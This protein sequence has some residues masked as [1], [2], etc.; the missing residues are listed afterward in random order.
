MPFDTFAEL[1]SAFKSAQAKF[2]QGK[3]LAA[4]DDLLEVF[5]YR[6]LSGKL[7]EG[8]LD[9]DLKVMQSLADLAALFGEFQAADDLL[10]S[11]V[12][13]Y[14]K[15]DNS[16]AAD[17]THLRRIQLC[18]DR[19]DLNLARNLL[20]E[21]APRIGNIQNIQF[22]SAGLN[23]WEAGCLWRNA[24][25]EDRKL[26]F[27]ELYFAMGRLLCS[28]GQYGDALKALYRSILYAESE[29]APDLAKQ[30]ILPLQ[31]IVASAYLEK[32]DF[33]KA[34]LYLQE[35]QNQLDKPQYPEYLIRW[36]ELSA[37]L[38]LLQGNFGKAFKNF[39]QVQDI[40]YKFDLRRA[41]LR[42][43]LNLAQFLILINQTNDAEGYLINVQMD[44]ITNDDILLARRAELLLNIARSR[45]LSLEVDSTASV[46]EML[47]G[48]HDRHQNFWSKEALIDISR[49][50]PNYLTWFEDRALAFQCFLGNFKIKAAGNLLQQIQDVFQF[51]DS[52]LIKVKI[53][54]LKGTFYYY[55]SI[56][57][58][59]RDRLLQANNILTEVCPQLAA[60]DLKPELWQVQRI[61]AWCRTSLH[62]PA[63]EIEAL[64]TSTNQLLEQI[65]ATLAPEDQI[66][67]LLNKWT[68][69]E[70]Y[71]AAK[72]NQ[73]QRMERNL[74]KNPFWLRLWYW[75]Q[76]RQELNKLVEHIDKYKGVLAKRIIQ[77]EKTKV[78][79]LRP[80]SLW[81]RFLTHPKH[82][83]SISFLILPDRVLVVITG[84][85]LFDFYVIPTTR[86]A[87]RNFIQRWYKTIEGINGSRDININD[88]SDYT[89]QMKSVKQVGQEIT[90]NLADI[91]QL[92]KILKRLPK[93]VR[94]LTIVPDDILHGFPF[95]AIT[96][97]DKY[98]IEHYALSITYESK[99]RRIKKSS[100]SLKKQALVIGVSN[101][102]RQFRPLP[103]VRR[104]L[105]RVNNWLE[106]H[107]INYLLLENNSACKTAVIESISQ[108]TLLHIACHGTFKPNQPDQSGLV[109]ISHTGEQQILSLR[110]LSSMNLTQLR[111]AT[112]S[113]CWSADHFILPR[114]WIISL[115]ETLWRAGTQSILGCMWEVD[116]KVAVSFMTRFYEHLDKYPRDEALR[117]TQLDCLQ[118]NLTDCDEDTANPLFWA[119]F[120]LYGDCG[121]LKITR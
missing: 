55:Q 70:E 92:P 88:D 18:L 30:A 107:K 45:S 117:R 14:N 12:T 99:D 5:T 37:K 74:K 119:G 53:S 97:K 115:P 93:H 42:S 60:M 79:F 1:N 39:Q 108:A 65:T 32:G 44:A 62:Y 106:R 91:L 111:H 84:Q 47:R 9:A 67:Y 61:L 86:L 104:E 15:T 73:L 71:I 68:A 83:V 20:Q 36:F 48:K 46:M 29:N 13:L 3:F 56:D 82:R 7:A 41:V 110:E 76:I 66:I 50:S 109:L 63:V 27:T 77:G 90:D 112:L 102:N 100:T 49:K 89:R 19:G 22:S 81:L 80:A 114:R 40:C 96:Y 120:N 113:S 75:F 6:L 94:A 103:G 51:T 118:G 72:I 2:F 116:D 35:L 64:S 26:L 28:L 85:F 34:N 16:S 38:N 98:L 54:I 25:S 121:A 69:D 57:Q 59:N 43:T 21:M 11:A 58:K 101:G 105:A 78:P 52:E 24:S 33:D 31:I 23:Q 10:C 87:V 4:Y 95:A 8:Y 17:Y